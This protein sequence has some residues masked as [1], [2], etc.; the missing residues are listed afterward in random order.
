MASGIDSPRRDTPLETIATAKR[1]FILGKGSI[2]SIAERYGVS[3]QGLYKR[4]VTEK[5][6]AQRTQ[7]GRVDDVLEL[8]DQIADLNDRIS[9]C[10]EPKDIDCLYRAKQ[11][12]LSMLWGIT[13]HPKPPVGE[14]PK[15]DNPA[16]AA[17]LKRLAGGSDTL[18]SSRATKKKRVVVD[19]TQ[20]V[21]ADEV[22]Y[23]GS[24]PL[25]ECVDGSGI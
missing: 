20:G 1:D 24:D 22:Q 10:D 12:A 14:R 11:R 19:A 18:Q 9:T 16:K 4:S 21:V 13:G 3:E 8:R 25:N 23:N 2:S 5:W 15:R 7:Y 17:M 6:S